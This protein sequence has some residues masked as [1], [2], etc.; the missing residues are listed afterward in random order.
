MAICNIYSCNDCK[1]EFQYRVG[2]KFLGIDLTCKCKDCNAVSVIFLPNKFFFEKRKEQMN[3]DKYKKICHSCTGENLI[4]VPE[5]E[6]HICHY[7]SSPNTALL[8]SRLTD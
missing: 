8:E 3:D 7:C 4:D 2:L 5:A 6:S 1:K